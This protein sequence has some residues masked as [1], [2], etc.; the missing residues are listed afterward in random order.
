MITYN[1]CSGS[2]FRIAVGI[3]MLVLLAG[4]ADAATIT[5]SASGGGDYMS[6]QAA[7]N[8]A[9][10]GDTIL[11]DSGTY[12]ENVDVSKQ[13][14]LRGVDNGGGKPVV[15]AKGHGD[16]I[17]LS[18]G[19]ST[20]DGFTVVNS[21]NVPE[22]AGIRVSSNENLIKNNIASH[23]F[24]GI[25]LTYN[26]NTLI[27]NDATSNNGRGIY[28]DGSSNNTLYGNHADFNINGGGIVLASFSHNNNLSGNYAL[29]NDNGIWLSYSN[30]N[31]IYNNFFNNNQNV[32]I[33][34][35]SSIWNTSKTSGANIIE[36]PYL[37]GNVWANPSGTGFSQTCVDSDKDGICDSPYTLDSSNIDYHPLAYVI[38]NDS[39]PLLT[40]AGQTPLNG[41]IINH[42]WIVIEI[43]SNKSLNAALLEW[44]GM[45]ESMGGLGINWQK[46]KT[47]LPN[48][49]YKFKV[50]GRDSSG[51]WNS[52]ELRVISVSAPPT[53][54]IVGG[55]SGT[56]SVAY[57]PSEWTASNFPAFWHEDGISGE[58]LSVNQQD[59]GSNQRAINT[60]NLV[61]SSSKRV[62]PYEVYTQ[63]G[64]TVW[65]GLDAS[66][67]S[68]I[69]GGYYA[70]VGWLGKSY[71]AVNGKADKLSEI[72]LEQKS[73]DFK[74]LNVNETWNLGKDYNLTLIALDTI[75][76]PKQALFNLSNKSGIISECIV[77]EGN[78]NTVWRNPAD[79]SDAPFFVTYIDNISK[80]SIRLK[81]TWLIS[82]NVKVFKTAKRFGIMEVR[83]TNSN[84]FSL[85][86]ENSLTLSRGS[87]VNLLE[88]LYLVVA[89]SASLEYYPMMNA[90]SPLALSILIND[91]NAYANSTFVNLSLTANN[92]D[93]MSFSNDGVSW[94]DWEKFETS[95]SWTLA[96][97][98][99]L[100][101]VYLKTGN[102]AGESAPVNDTIILDMT[103]PSVNI[104]FPANDSFVKVPDL[105]FIGNAT[106]SSGVKTGCIRQEWEAVGGGSG[107]GSMGC[108]GLSNSLTS[109]AF[110][111]SLTLHDGK[112]TITIIYGD[113]AGNLGSAKVNVTLDNIQPDVANLSLSTSTPG[114]NQSV[115]ITVHINGTN[116]NTSGISVLVKS[117]GGFM[118]TL[119]MTGFGGGRYYRNFTNTSEY[120]RYDVTILSSDLAGHTNDTMKTWFVTTK[121]STKML[122][123]SK[124]EVA[125]RSWIWTSTNFPDFV[126]E[127]NLNV[128]VFVNR[129]IPIEGLWYKIS[130]EIITKDTGTSRTLTTGETWSMGAGYEL[131]INALDARTNPRQV[132]FTLKKDG[133]E[134]DE[135]LLAEGGSYVRDSSPLDEKL[136]FIIADNI[137]NPGTPSDKVQLRFG[138]L[139][140]DNV[141]IIQPG[142]KYENLTVKRTSLDGLTLDKYLT[143]TQYLYLTNENASIDLTRDSSVK[144]LG[145]LYF[146]V[147]NTSNLSYYPYFKK[148]NIIDLPDKN[149]FL[150]ISINE[151]M[152][153][154][155]HITEMKDIPPEMSSD[156]AGLNTMNRFI[157]INISEGDHLEFVKIK[158]YYTQAELDAKGLKESELKILWH[159]ET[160]RKW[161]QI[162]LQGYNSTDVGTYTGHVWADLS[163]LSTFALAGKA[164]TSTPPCTNCNGGSNGGGGGSGGGVSGE[165][166]SNIEVIEKYDLQISKDALTSYRFTHAK[167][168]I[169]FV[170]ITGNTS[171]GIITTSIEVLKNTSTL[172]KTATNWLVYKNTNIWVGTSGFATPKNIKQGLIKFRVDNTWMSANGVSGSEIVLMKWDGSV[173]VTLETSESAKDDKY[174]Y[175][176]AKTQTFSSFAIV[177]LKGEKSDTASLTDV[178]QTSAKPIPTP[179]TVPIKGTP[180]FEIVTATAALC[181]I[182]LMRQKRK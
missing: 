115:N 174:T 146:K 114:I 55:S 91:G 60:G 6:I 167:N 87:T 20:L 70:K 58:M 31:K 135:S 111:H 140:S 27:G 101:T 81:Y 170:N 52:T 1:L 21:G 105:N 182:Y 18:M 143:L 51:N 88:N 4:G 165:N 176:E 112:N 150:E 90:T 141:V 8:A 74:N 117:P 28:L 172:V 13:L 85:S 24:N 45:N 82:D 168:P 103:P 131:T 136:F 75:V 153:S 67:Y 72:V 40:Y 129:S 47:A 65:N 89:D 154:D 149:M 17:T 104:T 37:G 56:G 98:D 5:V 152:A 161:E 73:T 22:N 84:G 120:G 64:L 50:Y 142:H 30:N 35:V 121:T 10:G 145:D 36:G 116:I 46:R 110:S 178:T 125:N 166:Y 23:N 69:R 108:G 99:S 137:Y 122:N 138:R 124:G 48:G 157:D 3:T 163:H 26:N 119:P 71:V 107:G 160:S 61:Y 41:S 77:E 164:A 147:D 32:Y 63:T 106:D 109:I 179:T 2:A 177:S 83:S 14:V 148:V 19:N 133:E 151:S 29:N 181:A 66:G 44:N 144:I 158:F 38:S 123:G 162:P 11:V 39:F 57:G 97:G 68:I 78:L 7:I 86:N 76:S 118:N 16:T 59:L 159:N 134:I 12:Y 155:I 49:T 173:W 175:Y 100:K 94:S 79:E 180:G 126:H 54:R 80:N 92:A 95:K 53:D 25:Y 9:H 156:L 96:S 127:D 113:V 128:T 33:Y 43:F 93:I 102:S 139:T 15:D 169:M 42:K 171:L 132:W 34:S 62:V 130:R